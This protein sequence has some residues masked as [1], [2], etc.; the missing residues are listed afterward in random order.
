M[1]IQLNFAL[2]LDDYLAAQRLYAKSNWWLHLN[3]FAGRIVLPVM[4]ACTFVLAF[5]I[6]GKGVP[7]VIFLGM[8]GLG[9]LLALYPLYMRFRLKQCYRRTRTDDGSCTLELNENVIRMQGS[10]AKSEVDWTAVKSTA[11]NDKVILIYLAPAKFYVIPKR[12][13]DEQQLNEVRE[14]CKHKLSGQQEVVA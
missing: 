3:Q 2:S 14:L 13:C 8:V 6:S 5:L 10:N 11:E 4:G 7:W 9:I 1:P 12:A